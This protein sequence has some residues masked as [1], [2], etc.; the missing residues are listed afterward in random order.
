MA[1]EYFD[2][3]EA[4]VRPEWSGSAILDVAAGGR[5]GFGLIQSVAGSAARVLV[6]PA[7]AK[8]TVGL[9]VNTSAVATA[10]FTPIQFQSDGGT[11]THLSLTVTSP[12]SSPL[13]LEL[14]R[15]TSAGTLLAT[16]TQLFALNT[17]Q[18]IEM[19]ATIDDV[20]GTCIVRVDGVEWINFTGDTRNAGTSTNIDTLRMVWGTLTGPPLIKFDDVYVLNGTDATIT[21]GRPDNDF[22]GVV[23]V[24][25]LYPDGNGATSQWVGSDGNTTDNYLLIDETTMSTADYVATGT[26]GARDLWTVSNVSASTQQVLAI[27][28]FLNAV[29]LDTG[30]A[31]MATLIRESSGT[32]TADA[33]T[34]ELSTTYTSIYGPLRPTKPSGGAWTVSEVNALQVGAEKGTP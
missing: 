14:R 30:T 15:G 9:A 13:H 16:S 23:S 2:G 24:E 18:Y 4:G 1:I 7:S 19:Q 33:T 5:T 34:N 21:T 22:L 29:K 27:Q 11:T 26:D 28:T 10:S 32:V 17:W 8:K 25:A 6:L 20:T 12:I 31:H 3:F